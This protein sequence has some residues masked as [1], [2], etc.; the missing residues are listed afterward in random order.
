MGKCTRNW[1][2]GISGPHWRNLHDIGDIVWK[3][4][5]SPWWDNQLLSSSK[6][7]ILHIQPANRHQGAHVST[8]NFKKCVIS[9]YNSPLSFLWNREF[10]WYYHSIITKISLW[11]PVKISSCLL[12]ISLLLLF[13]L[14]RR[15]SINIPTSSSSRLYILYVA[16]LYRP[17]TSITRRHRKTL[18]TQVIQRRRMNSSRKKMKTGVV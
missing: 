7:V 10:A 17:A 15:K 18:L 2:V 13:I 9:S 6:P 5:I 4:W 16:R 14:G 1:R 3:I 8:W 12:M 11:M